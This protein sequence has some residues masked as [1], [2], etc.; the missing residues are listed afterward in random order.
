MELEEAVKKLTEKVDTI[1]TAFEKIEGKVDGQETLTQ[2]WKT[3]IG[4][5][6][7]AI[8]EIKET[9]LESETLKK[10]VDKVD[11]LGENTNSSSEKKP[12]GGTDTDDG[13][14]E[15]DLSEA[16]KA[17]ADEVFSKLTPEERSHIGNDQSKR[18]QFLQAAQAA[19][20]EVPVSLFGE[21]VKEQI[22]KN[23]FRKM[24]G[25][26]DKEAGHMPGSTQG[27]SNFKGAS[28]GI[29]EAND[30]QMTKR[31]PGG[32]LPKAGKQ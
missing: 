26:I 15:K 4:D 21:P 19:T 28:I 30:T 8:K 22:T 27:S 12:Q 7:T 10:L 2:A 31:L 17:K 18:K 14:N 25:M 20:A 32:V 3:E 16:A 1:A 24:F 23:D 9:G 5:V 6:R 13:W 29:T 11:A